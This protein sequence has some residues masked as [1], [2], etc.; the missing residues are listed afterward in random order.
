MR[1][2]QLL[3]P[4]LFI[5]RTPAANHASPIQDS[6]ISTVYRVRNVV[7][8]LQSESLSV[9]GPISAGRWLLSGS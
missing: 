9:M 5:F 3:F 1:V 4:Y 8:Q 6:C 2:P 7:R